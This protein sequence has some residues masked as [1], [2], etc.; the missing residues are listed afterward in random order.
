[1]LRLFALNPSRTPR[2]TNNRCASICTNGEANTTG[3]LQHQAD[4][5]LSS[6]IALPFFNSATHPSAFHPLHKYRQRQ[7]C[8]CPLSYIFRLS[9]A[10]ISCPSC[11]PSWLP[12]SLLFLCFSPLSSKLF[13]V[14]SPLPNS[15]DA[16]I[17]F[18]SSH[19]SLLPHL[20]LNQQTT[21]DP[22]FLNLPPNPRGI[23][24]PG[25]RAGGKSPYYP[26]PNSSPDTAT[27]AS[28]T[29]SSQE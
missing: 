8:K 25:G 21:M 6:P 13:Y 16:L 23:R 14:S 2:R 11:F 26:P 15:E 12:S 28:S 22:L 27:Q 9:H 4:I 19:S 7:G 5:R 17:L 1:M 24:R 20:H 29:P 10:I 3:P 18:Q